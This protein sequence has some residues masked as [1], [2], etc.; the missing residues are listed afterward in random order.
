M[1]AEICVGMAVLLASVAVICFMLGYC[2][3]R[4]DANMES[5]RK[6]EKL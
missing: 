1:N 3:G 6:G 4:G 5:Y 2:K